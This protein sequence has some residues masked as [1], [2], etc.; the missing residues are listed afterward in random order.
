LQAF[1]GHIA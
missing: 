1:W